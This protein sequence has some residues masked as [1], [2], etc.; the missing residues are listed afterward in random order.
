MTRRPWSQ[1]VSFLRLRGC[2]A[3]ARAAAL[4]SAGVGT[5]LFVS[6]AAPPAGLPAVTTSPSNLCLEFWPALG[7]GATGLLP[8]ISLA[9]LSTGADRGF[10]DFGFGRVAKLTVAICPPWRNKTPNRKSSRT[11]PQKRRHRHRRWSRPW[12]WRALARPLMTCQRLTGLLPWR[13]MAFMTCGASGCAT[14][15]HAGV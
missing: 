2:W 13:S 3:K 14:P 4:I 1:P 6:G 8:P 12:G 15:F 11:A 9:D 7:I 5:A 10:G